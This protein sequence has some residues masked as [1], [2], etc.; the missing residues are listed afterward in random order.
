MR[1]ELRGRQRMTEQAATTQ[2]A[3]LASVCVVEFRRVIFEICDRVHTQRER[4]RERQTRSSQYFAP[5]PGAKH[6]SL[7]R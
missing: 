1:N 4:E 3:Q 2:R 6:N 5:V 7:A